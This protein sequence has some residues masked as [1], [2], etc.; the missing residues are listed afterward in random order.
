MLQYGAFEIAHVNESS[1]YVAFSIS[2]INGDFCRKSQSFSTLVCLTPPL[3]QFPLEFCNAGRPQNRV[4]PIPDGGQSLTICVICVS[5]S[6]QYQCVTD[7][8]RDRR[9]DL[10]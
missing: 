2:E 7:R 6:L 3:R 4:M 8:Q 1:N 9:T 10:P 5:V